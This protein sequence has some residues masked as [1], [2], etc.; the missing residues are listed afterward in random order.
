MS[1]TNKSIKLF[2]LFW[3][4]YFQ[5]SYM[6]TTKRQFIDG[7]AAA[8]LLAALLLLS[9]ACHAQ[10]FGGAVCGTGCIG[11]VIWRDGIGFLWSQDSW[12]QVDNTWRR[13]SRTRTATHHPVSHVH[14]AN[15]T[16]AAAPSNSRGT[17][18]TR[19]PETPLASTESTTPAS[20][21]PTPP[22]HSRLPYGPGWLVGHPRAT[23][24]WSMESGLAPRSKPWMGASSVE[25]TLQT[26]PADKAVSSS[27]SPFAQPWV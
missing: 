6:A 26:R 14:P 19:L 16:T 5:M 20:S 21:R 24:P 2:Q 25:A 23:M 11:S 3:S 10:Q 12:S 9:G 27:T 22:S 1:H 17:T 7:V 4:S 13:L 8:V 18:T 15:G